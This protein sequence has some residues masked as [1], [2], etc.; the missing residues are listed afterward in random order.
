MSAP[1]LVSLLLLLLHMR[2]RIMRKFC[3]SHMSHMSPAVWIS[4]VHPGGRRPGGRRP[5]A[6]REEASDDDEEKKK[7]GRRR[8]PGKKDDEPDTDEDEEAKRP[9]EKK[10][11]DSR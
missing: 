3:F 1:R 9:G 10:A 6:G 2:K 11:D 5:G 4:L 7:A 8:R